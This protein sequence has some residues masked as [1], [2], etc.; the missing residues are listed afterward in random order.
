M[1]YAE[2][3]VDLVGNTPLVKLNVGDRGHRGHGAGQGRVLQ[4]RRVGE[5]PHRAAMIEAAEESGEL[6]PGGTI[7]EPTRGNTGVGLAI[8]AQRGATSASSSAPTRCQPGQDQRA[9]GVRRRGRGLPDRR[10]ARAPGLL[11]LRLRPAGPRDPRRLEARPVLQPERPAVALRDDRPGDLGARP[12]AGSP[13]SSPASAP[14]APSPAPAATSRR[15]RDARV[16]GCRSSAPTRRARSTP[17]APGG[18]TSS[19]ASARTSGRRPTTPRGV[20][21]IVAVSDA[22]SF[23]MTRRLA[24]EEGLLVGGSCGMAVV[25]ALRVAEDLPAGRRGRRAAARRRARLPVED[26]QR[27][28]DGRL[29]L[30]AHQRRDA[31]SATCCD[32]KAGDLP[33][34]VH[35]HPNETVR[36]A[37]EILREYGVSQMPVVKAEPPV[38]AGEVVGSV[39][40]ARPARRAVHRQGAPGRPGVGST[41]PRRCRWSAPASRSATA[42]QALEKADAVLVLDDGKPVG[43]ADP[44]DLLAFLAD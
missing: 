43:R 5:G 19:R 6:K 10:R 8:V 32:G 7:V 36:E 1:K 23:E 21:E 2:H 41:W 28:V 20:D 34:L 26:L 31:R 22:D 38:M 44:A 24:R 13:T 37:I 29:R 15:S 14:A 4:P 12:T 42:R 16:A 11:L 18:R 25:A 40:R 17:A 33:A 39:S 27:R 35:T 9:P 30:P 3:I